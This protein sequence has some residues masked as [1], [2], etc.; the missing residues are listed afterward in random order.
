MNLVCGP[1]YAITTRNAMAQLS[2]RETS[3]EIIEVCLFIAQFATWL[4]KY[5]PPALFDFA[6]KTLTGAQATLALVWVHH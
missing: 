2:E 5:L 6:W 1:E 3:F 4:I